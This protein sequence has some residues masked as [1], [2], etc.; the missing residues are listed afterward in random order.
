MSRL[1]DRHPGGRKRHCRACFHR[2]PH[3]EAACLLNGHIRAAGMSHVNVP[4]GTMVLS[5]PRDYPRN[6]FAAWPRVEAQIG[7]YYF[8]VR[9]PD[10][11]AETWK[12]GEFFVVALSG[13]LERAAEAGPN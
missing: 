2:E 13:A 8:R 7:K 5:M 10:G 12:R 1:R 4:P 9:R 11:R 6:E 3:S